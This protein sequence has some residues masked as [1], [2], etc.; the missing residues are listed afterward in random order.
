MSHSDIC[1]DSPFYRVAESE[2]Y[3]KIMA[4]KTRFAEELEL[5]LVAFSD[6][7]HFQIL[8]SPLS[9]YITVDFV[10]KRTKTKLNY[11]M[12]AKQFREPYH[13]FDTVS[14]AI[15]NGHIY[16][17]YER[18]PELRE[19]THKVMCICYD[20][21]KMSGLGTRHG[22]DW[23]NDEDSTHLSNVEMERLLQISHLQIQRERKE[24]EE[25]KKRDAD[26]IASIRSGF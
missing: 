25:R 11:D 16:G 18:E 21:S 12:D 17:L 4:V 9:T 14:I 19:I 3:R 1:E 6:L 13:T 23:I 24:Q 2:T 7:K 5:R 20:V 26:F 15:N 22:E 10:Y 8:H